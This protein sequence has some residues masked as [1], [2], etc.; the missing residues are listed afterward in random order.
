MEPWQRLRPTRRAGP[1]DSSS[2][3]AIPVFG[4]SAVLS[5]EFDRRVGR[6]RDHC[7]EREHSGRLEIVRP[8][9]ARLVVVA[10]LIEDRDRTR[11]R[12]ASD[13]RET[14]K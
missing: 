3:R 12:D 7:Y 1:R 13:G 5:G 14:E 6:Q 8:S 4:W 11:G 2:L 9:A 10:N